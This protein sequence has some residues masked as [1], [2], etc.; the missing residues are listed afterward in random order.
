MP[1]RH[2]AGPN[3]SIETHM[4]DGF[5]IDA[6][7]VAL[8]KAILA[9]F[10]Q[11][12]WEELGYHLRKHDVVVGHSRLLRSLSWGDE[13]YGG[14][15]FAVL[16]RLLGDRYENL[17][18]IEKFVGLQTW[19]GKEEPELYT[20][21]YD[22]AEFPTVPL[23]QVE[24]AS[25]IHD[26]TELNLHAARIRS[27]IVDDPAQA[28]GS[29]KELL[30]TVMK[31][32]LEEHDP[33]SPDEIPALLKRVR[34]QL[35]LDPKSAAATTNDTLRKCLG[36]LGQLV[37]GVAEIRNVH[38]TGHGRSKSRELEIPHARLVV[39]SAITAATFLLEV[40]QESKS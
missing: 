8:Q 37:I 10:D 36:S 16:R 38:G 19:L 4:K 40:W 7:I 13:D 12:R 28:I 15:V 17:G 22:D 9:T 11:G 14:N 18:R 24:Q 31:T 27:S 39:N 6:A 33:R 29:A 3:K 21:L 2:P 25:T 26:V 30:E 34:A 23:E 20:E 32:I 35:D 5:S 1:L